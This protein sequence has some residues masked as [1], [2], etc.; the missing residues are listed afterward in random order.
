MIRTAKKR[1]NIEIERFVNDILLSPDYFVKDTNYKLDSNADIVYS[2]NNSNKL[3]EKNYKSDTTVYIETLINKRKELVE[4]YIANSPQM[5]NHEICHQMFRNAFRGRTKMFIQMYNCMKSNIKEDIITVQCSLVT[6]QMLKYDQMMLKAMNDKNDNEYRNEVLKYYRPYF[7]SFIAEIKRSEYASIK[8]LHEKLYSKDRMDDSYI[9]MQCSFLPPNDE[10]IKLSGYVAESAS[11][12]DKIKAE[13]YLIK[14]K[15]L[16]QKEI[17]EI[18]ETYKIKSKCIRED[19][20]FIDF[21]EK[22]IN[23][24]PLLSIKAYRI[25]NGNCIFMR[26]GKKN[27]GFFYDIGFNCKH[28]PQKIKHGVTYNYSDT[29]KKIVNNKPNFIVLSHWDM[30]HIAGISATRKDFLDVDWFAPDCFDACL[31]AKRLALFLS[32]KD[33]LILADRKQG[34]RLIGGVIEISSTKKE[35]IGQ[36]KFYIG[37]KSGCDFSYPNCEGIV[38]EYTCFFGGQ[39]KVILMMG[40]VNYASFN[41]ARQNSGELEIADTHID[42]LVVPHHGSG[43]TDYIKLTD[44]RHFKTK[45]GKAIICCINDVQS[46]RPNK[47]HLEVLE[48]RFAEVVATE[49]AKKPPYIRIPL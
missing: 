22:K 7:F 34:G 9:W 44:G 30:D 43:H 49:G 36:Y 20:E 11:N 41:K 37:E 29:M 10:H 25:G 38:I 23:N 42:Y 40:D 45:V 17:D 14:N 39:K 13:L 15:N 3:I 2:E 27:K 12:F 18:L 4:E 46:D 32:M 48:E 33:H 1:L 47:K 16:S 5:T 8:K 19:R 6:S 31:D 28:R 24:M 21:L 26:T 35:K